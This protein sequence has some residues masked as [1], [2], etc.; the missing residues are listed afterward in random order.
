MFCTGGIRCEKSTAFL[1]AEGLDEVYHLKGGILKYLETIPP[2]QSLWQGECFVFDHRVA[3]AHGLAPGTHVICHAC[4]RPI[5]A[6]GR[7][8]PEYVPGIRCEACSSERNDEQ[9]AGYAERHRQEHLAA[10]R[11]E[12]HVGRAQLPRDR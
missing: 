6:Q 8:A 9:R 3:V 5:S 11:G 1:K 12:A 10:T 4:R 7:A 2:D